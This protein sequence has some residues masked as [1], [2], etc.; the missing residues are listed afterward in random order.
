M[1]FQIFSLISS[2]L[3]YH[4]PAFIGNQMSIINTNFNKFS[5]L[6]F[7]NQQKLYIKSSQFHHGLG[8][9]IY[10][11]HEKIEEKEHIN[12]NGENFIEKYEQSND[13]NCSISIFNRKPS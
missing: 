5:S 4:S 12:I 8:G 6:L 9:I 2:S 1:N 10:N 11:D 7:L 3:I 13:K